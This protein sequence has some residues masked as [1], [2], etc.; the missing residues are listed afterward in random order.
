[1]KLIFKAVPYKICNMCC[2]MT[3]CTFIFQSPD[4]LTVGVMSPGNDYVLGSGPQ[5]LLRILRS[6]A[7]QQACE[8]GRPGICKFT[9]NGKSEAQKTN[10]ATQGFIATT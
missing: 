4:L 8:F 1:M 6:S 10:A 7:L 2:K 3:P 5:R 9:V